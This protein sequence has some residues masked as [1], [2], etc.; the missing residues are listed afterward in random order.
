[1]RASA[2][3]REPDAG[4]RNR[5]NCE[6]A[7]LSSS[8]LAVADLNGDGKLDVA[9]SNTFDGVSLLFGACLP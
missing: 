5:V 2:Q 4:Q 3:T 8:V 7:G 6:L 1:M 9:T